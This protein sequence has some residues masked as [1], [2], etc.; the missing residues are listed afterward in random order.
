MD[1]LHQQLEEVDALLI[2]QR[3]AL[4]AT[5]TVKAIEY[6]L[7]QLIARELPRVSGKV[8]LRINDIERELGKGD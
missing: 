5:Q 1:R 4:A 3:H 8:R 7:R 6:A 2:S